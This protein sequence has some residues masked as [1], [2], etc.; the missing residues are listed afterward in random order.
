MTDE[1]KE[2]DLKASQYLLYKLDRTIAILG[3]IGVALTAMLIMGADGKDVALAGASVLGGYIGG[4]AG[5]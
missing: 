1:I 4:R 3:I 2:T 5:K